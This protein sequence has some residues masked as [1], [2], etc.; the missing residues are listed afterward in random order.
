[1]TVKRLDNRA[2]QADPALAASL[3]EL[4]NSS[5]VETSLLDD[6]S[7]LH[8]VSQSFATLYTPEA[9]ALLITL[10]H[11]AEYESPNF[12]W[13]QQRYDRFIYIDRVIVSAAARGTGIGRKLYEALFALAREADQTII[14][15]EVNIDPPNPGSDAFHA[16]MGFAE[17]GIVT[18]PHG[19]T[20]RFLT[21][22]I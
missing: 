7:L 18:H 5:A 21:R 8:L 15:C 3:L 17:A 10:P 1:M 2:L 20:V 11:S 6:A 14:T 9:S 22:A 12:R 16:A 13:F 19:K 4:N